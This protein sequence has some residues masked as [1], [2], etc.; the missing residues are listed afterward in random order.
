MG[1]GNDEK[2]GI[3][4]RIKALKEAFDA[5]FDHI[6]GSSDR[7]EANIDRKLHDFEGKMGENRQKMLIPIQKLIKNSQK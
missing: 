3:L 5:H 4:G 1:V 7:F 6:E 2:V